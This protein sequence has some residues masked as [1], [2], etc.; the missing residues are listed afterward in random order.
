MSVEK[1]FIHQEHN[2]A[3]FLS[4]EYSKPQNFQETWYHK[5]PE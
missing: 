2:Y 4:S 1:S 3:S 5:D